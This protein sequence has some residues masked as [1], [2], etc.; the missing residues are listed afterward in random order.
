MRQTV[1]FQE[2]SDQLKLI[3]QL[4]LNFEAHELIEYVFNSLDHD[5]MVVGVVGNLEIR[6]KGTC[7]ECRF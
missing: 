4:R 3:P 6:I 5:N 1:N 7:M 2:F